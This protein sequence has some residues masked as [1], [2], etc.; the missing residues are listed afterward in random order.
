[1]FRPSFDQYERLQF[2]KCP[3]EGTG[4]HPLV[5]SRSGHTQ[6][7]HEDLFSRSSKSASEARTTMADTFPQCQ[8]SV[9]A[10]HHQSKLPREWKPSKHPGSQCTSMAFT[11]ILTSGFLPVGLWTQTIMDRI[12]FLGDKLH[13][14]LLA[15]MGR[16]AP[17]NG[18]L[19]ADEMPSQPKDTH[20]IWGVKCKRNLEYQ[21]F[22]HPDL[23]CLSSLRRQLTECGIP[24]QRLRDLDDAISSCFS[25]G[26]AGCL[27]TS[28]GVS[29]A[30]FKNPE[31]GVVVFDSHA[32]D[33]TGRTCS[34]GK[35]SLLTFI[36]LD[37][38]VAYYRSQLGGGTRYCL[39]GFLVQPN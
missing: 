24:D 14:C 27:L 39:T 32:K 20:G 33:V 30:I 16:W 23:T 21:G 9:L 25:A 37:G 34:E 36:S 6:T 4:N 10:S 15:E 28:C 3:C 2:R 19:A 8:K 12:L 38:V 5:P 31:G 13:A 1:M 22:I 18:H 29:S 17:C 11:A 7:S 26:S 35:S